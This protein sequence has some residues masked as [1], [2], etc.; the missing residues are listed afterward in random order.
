MSLTD[1]LL[2]EGVW[3][4]PSPFPYQKNPYTTP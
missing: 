3:D 4:A 1:Q 2:Q